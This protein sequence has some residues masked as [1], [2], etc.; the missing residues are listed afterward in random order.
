MTNIEITCIKLTSDIHEREYLYCCLSNN[1]NSHK[2]N[3]IS[4]AKTQSII[5]PSSTPSTRALHEDIELTCNITCTDTDIAD[6]ERERERASSTRQSVFVG[7]YERFVPSCT[8]S[9]PSESN[10]PQSLHLKHSLCQVF[11]TA[12][13]LSDANGTCPHCRR[14]IAI[15]ITYAFGVRPVIIR[16]IS[17]WRA[18]PEGRWWRIWFM[19]GGEWGRCVVSWVAYSMA[20]LGLIKVQGAVHLSRECVISL[21]INL[22]ATRSQL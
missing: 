19:L 22:L 14:S 21:P 11:F 17:S 9:L 16:R 20:G 1:H 4:L 6:T 15:H 10:V 3:H 12:R 18:S 13:R 8:D 5:K 2:N 7:Q